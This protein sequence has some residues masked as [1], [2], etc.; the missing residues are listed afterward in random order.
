MDIVALLTCLRLLVTAV[1]L[2]HLAQIVPALLTMTGRVTMLGRA[3]WTEKGGHY[4][5]R[6]RFFATALPWTKLLVQFFR[7]HLYQREHEFL[8]AGDVRA[9][10][11]ARRRT[12]S[13]VFFGFGRAG[14]AWVGVFR[15]VVSGCDAAQ[16]I[17][18]S[19]CAVSVPNFL[20][21]HRSSVIST[22]IQFSH[23][24]HEVTSELALSPL[25][26]LLL[27]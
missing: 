22:N 6:Q 18:L 4:R 19:F 8:L 5:T 11:L 13:G 25:R 20:P 9:P 24:K 14:G 1:T 7:P 2:R 23:R 10:K 27:H 26:A 12:E 15:L 21:L 3:R 16:G 17:S